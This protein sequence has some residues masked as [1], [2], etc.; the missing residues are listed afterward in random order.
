MT[1]LTNCID[2]PLFY[3]YLVANSLTVG[4]TEMVTELTTLLDNFM[5]STDPPHFTSLSTQ[6]AI[7]DRVLSENET[8]GSV[9]LRK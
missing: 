4:R 6:G 2:S 1:A 8:R 7:G 9:E 3:E 5:S